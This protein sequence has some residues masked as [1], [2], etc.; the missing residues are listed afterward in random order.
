MIQAATPT[1]AWPSLVAASPEL[2]RFAEEAIEAAR[3]RASWWP[4][5]FPRFAGFTCLLHSES[6]YHAAV[7]HLVT[8]FRAAW[9]R[10]WGGEPAR[11]RR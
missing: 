1:L 2:Q 9:R 8:T 10:C 3:N 7:N 6:Q 11:A 4:S 5:W